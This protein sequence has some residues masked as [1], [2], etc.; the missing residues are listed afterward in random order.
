[1][2][3]VSSE[4]LFRSNPA[5]PMHATFA[6]F[7]RLEQSTGRPVRLAWLWLLAAAGLALFG[8]L[9]PNR[10]APWLSFHAESAMAGAG[11]CAAA[12]VLWRTRVNAARWP[13]LATLTAAAALV[14]AFQHALGILLFRG[15]AWLTALYFA[16]FAL[17]QIVGFRIVTSEGLRRSLEPLAW[18]LLTG[19]LLSSWLALYQWQSLEYFWIFA[20]DIASGMRPYANFVQPNLLATMLVLGLISTAVLYHFGRFGPFCGLLLTGVVGF[21]L[22]MTQ[23]RA[24]MLELLLVLGLLLLKRDALRDGQLSPRALCVAA[25]VLF[26]MPFLWEATRQAAPLTTGRSVANLVQAGMR[27][28]HWQSMIDAISRQ[29]W[30]GYGVNQTIVAQYIVAP[31]RP[32]THELLGHSHNLFLDLVVWMGVPIGITL[33]GALLAWGMIALRR[34]ADGGAVLALAAVAAVLAHAM[35]EYPLYYAY[36]LLPVGLLVGGISAHLMLGASTPVPRLLTPGLIL[37]AAMAL[38]FTVR[39]YWRLEEDVRTVRFEQA[40]I[41][42]TQRPLSEPRLLTQLGELLQFMRTS[43]RAGMSDADIE[44][45]H[46]VVLRFPGKENIVRYA[47]A[48]TLNGRPKE[49]AAALSRICK[50]V[51]EVACQDMQALWLALGRR[52][53]SI[54]S[55]PWPRDNPSD[56]AAGLLP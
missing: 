14:P 55:V 30:F 22:A 28:E 46:R 20:I 4:T 49:A 47:A 10:Y 9:T 7:M 50:T 18:L 24:G 52:E 33:V 32:A 12:W 41:A 54:A 16:A 56:A 13:W 26:A 35:V 53:A 51:D 25:M 8:W 29:P 11:L 5:Y 15:D 3:G 48:L 37:V 17:A 45:M 2:K 39:D 27:G 6:S 1:M 21:A 34:A 31:D 19:A 43:E 42:T 44:R 36:F 23:S 40:R 38:A